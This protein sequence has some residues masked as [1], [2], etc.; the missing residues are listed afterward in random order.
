ML[1]TYCLH[2][3][4]VVNHE[5]TFL[6]MK[7]CSLCVQKTPGVL[8]TLQPFPTHLKYSTHAF[9]NLFSDKSC[10]FALEFYNCNSFLLKSRR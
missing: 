3:L 10:I 6:N 4:I 9:T 2:F 5:E 8:T 7:L 1:F